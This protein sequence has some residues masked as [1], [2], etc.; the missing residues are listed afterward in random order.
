MKISASSLVAAVDLED[1]LLHH[2]GV[3]RPEA[4][5]VAQVQLGAGVGLAVVPAQLVLLKCNR[6]V[7]CFWLKMT[8]TTALHIIS[9]QE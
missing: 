6:I 3:G 7:E 9:L 8:F 4:A 5:H 2:E 1:V